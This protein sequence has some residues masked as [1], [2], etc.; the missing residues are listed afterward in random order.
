MKLT[1]G[2]SLFLAFVLIGLYSNA[3]V[4]LPGSNFRQKTFILKSDSLQIDTLSIIP[5]TLIISRVPHSD[6]RLD[7]IHSMVYFTKRPESDTVQITYR[8]FPYKLNPVA[9]RI[10]FDSIINRDYIQPFTYSENNATGQR[11]MFDFGSLKA[12]GSFG[13]QIAFG[14]RIGLIRG[15]V[16]GNFIDDQ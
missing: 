15:K 16:W 7:F 4:I 14:S 11:G 1:G 9:Q 6:Y 12:N 2:I 13:R 8:V 3:Q 10:N 5:R